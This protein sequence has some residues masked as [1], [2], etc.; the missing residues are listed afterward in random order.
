M[1]EEIRR[2]VAYAAAARIGNRFPG[3]IYGFERG[4]HSHMSE[5]FD[6][7]ARSHLS[8]VH[9]GNMYHYGLRAHIQ[10]TVQDKTFSGYD[11]ESRSHFS[12][13]VSGNQI[14]L[15]DY[16]ERRYFNFSV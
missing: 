2:A 7:E 3:S 12:G 4:K 5:N 9:S 14:K 8:G 6:Y 10:L 15:Y 13:T 1:C 11:Y 16:G